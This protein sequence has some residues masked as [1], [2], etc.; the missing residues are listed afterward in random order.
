MNQ[1]KNVSYVSTNIG[2]EARPFTRGA[3]PKVI[4]VIS[5]KM[6]PALW[7]EVAGEF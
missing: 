4:W 5:K 6:S 1:F 3:G 7:E 2:R